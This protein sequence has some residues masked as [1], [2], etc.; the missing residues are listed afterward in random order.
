MAAG[1]VALEDQN[2]RGIAW[3]GDGGDLDGP[4][5]ATEDV[6]EALPGQL[7]ADI[8][9]ALEQVS[10]IYPVRSRIR[11][12]PQPASVFPVTLHSECTA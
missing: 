4:K 5:V 7:D 1:P 11:N 8:M 10:P 3:G 12:C 2:F 6:V 9:Q